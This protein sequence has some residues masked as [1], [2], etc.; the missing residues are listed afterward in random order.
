MLNRASKTPNG[1]MENRD[2]VWD[3]IKDMR[4]AMMVTQDAAGH[5]FARPMAAM[6]KDDQ[7]NLWFFTSGSSPKV[8]EIRENGNILL[9]YSDPDENNYVS[10]MGTGIIVTDHAKI[11]ELW[12]DYLKAWFPKGKDDP[13]IVL[14]KVAPETAEYWDSPSSTFVKAFGYVKA[15][16]TGEPE[17]FGENEKTNL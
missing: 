16:V 3:L 4:F 15:R 10:L 1:N 9:S 17:D 7:D 13:D 14:I 8:R 2:K 6:D 12:V 5:M 11:E